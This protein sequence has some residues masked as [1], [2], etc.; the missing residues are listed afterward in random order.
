MFAIDCHHHGA[1]TLASTDD[2]RRMDHTDHGIVMEVECWCG[3]IVTV[4]TG[5]AATTQPA[6]AASTPA[7]PAAVAT[8]ATVAAS[9]T[10]ATAVTSAIAASPTSDRELVGC[11]TAA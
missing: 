7:A 1:R 11:G 9:A 2:I 5:R 6:R 4:V 10:S 8:P 3:G